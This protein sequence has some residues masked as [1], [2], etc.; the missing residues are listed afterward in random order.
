MSTII[1]NIAHSEL[2]EALVEA[3]PNSLDI[4]TAVY[5]A[6][7]RVVETRKQLA[8]IGIERQGCNRNALRESAGEGS[9]GL[10]VIIGDKDPSVCG[11][12]LAVRCR[13]DCKLV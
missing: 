10:A 13:F 5:A 6:I 2:R 9:P 3:G 8:S 7:V 12:P 11:D 1:R 4:G